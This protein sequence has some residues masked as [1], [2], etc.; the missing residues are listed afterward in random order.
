M[1]GAPE[2]D[3]EPVIEALAAGQ[4][5]GLPTDTVYG[6]AGALRRGPIDRIFEAKGRPPGLALP[7]LIGERHQVDAVASTFP[8]AAVRLAERFWPGPLTI[9]VRAKRAVG[10]LVGG[11]GRSV[12]I[13][14]PAH[15]LVEQVCLAVGPIAMTSANRHGEPACTSA[16]QL[17]AIFDPG[18]VTVIVDGGPCDGASSTVID[19]VSRTPSCMREGALPWAEIEVAL[20]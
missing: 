1:S 20:A 13:R 7:V 16:E 5:V 15:P 14:W 9:V 11:D 12:G 4:V 2:F 17:R 10:A 19:C 8:E 6:L 3:L 18:E